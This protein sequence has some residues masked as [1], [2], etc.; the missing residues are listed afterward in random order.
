MTAKKRKTI[1]PGKI[2]SPPSTRDT[3]HNNPVS[4]Y[5]EQKDKEDAE[6]FEYACSFIVKDFETEGPTWKDDFE[7][8][9]GCDIRTHLLDALA[10]QSSRDQTAWNDA[11]Y[12]F[13]KLA[14]EKE[15]EGRSCIPVIDVDRTYFDYREAAKPIP[16]PAPMKKPRD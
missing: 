9:L 14:K 4:K 1:N 3:V 13:E 5:F 15:A 12:K 8:L 6:L 2:N 16:D 11:K 7:Q 10:T